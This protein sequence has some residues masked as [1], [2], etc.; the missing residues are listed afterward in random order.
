[1]RQVT[2]Q[3]PQVTTA[4]VHESMAHSAPAEHPEASAAAGPKIERSRIVVGYAA[5]AA[6]LPYLLLKVVWVYGGGL[7][8]MD[9]ELAEGSTLFVANLATMGMDGVAV[10]IALAFTHRWGQRLPAWL[11]LFPMWIATGYLAPIV[12]IA[13]STGV[14]AQDAVDKDPEPFLASWVYV[15]VYGGFAIQGLLL[16][17]AFVLYARH[18][19]AAAFRGR[20]GEM[21]P[22]ATH[23]VQS[24]LASASAAVVAAVHFAWAAGATFGLPA[25]LAAHRTVGHYVTNAAYG[26]FALAAAVGLPLLVHCIPRRAPVRLLVVLTWL[27]GGSML[28]WGC[29]T[30]ITMGHAH[31]EAALG[32][33]GTTVYVLVTQM[34]IVAGALVGAIGAH[35]LAERFSGPRTQASPGVTGL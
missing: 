32:H 15:V 28:A 5:V 25:D 34:E 7:G 22:G 6:T 13:P 12:T 8:I 21:L 4:A 29:W 19:W 9:R 18:R 1:M 20:A 35:L 30:L 33:D 3:E 11:V 14:S 10:L 2:R 17:T 23:P 16:A 24:F 31:P 27:G 26:A